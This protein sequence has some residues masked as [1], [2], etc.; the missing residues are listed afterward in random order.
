ML[1]ICTG[2]VGTGI[3]QAKLLDAGFWLFLILC[4]IKHGFSV[5]HVNS[6]SDMFFFPLK[7]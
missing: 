7:V 5:M 1:P 3:A 2:I 6:V 4:R